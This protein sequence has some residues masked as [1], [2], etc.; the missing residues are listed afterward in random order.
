MWECEIVVD[1][2]A[3]SC[4]SVQSVISKFLVQLILRMDG[5]PIIA[6]KG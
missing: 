3:V 1:R 6:V 2:A 5:M 4:K